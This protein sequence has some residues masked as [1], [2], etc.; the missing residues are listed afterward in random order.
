MLGTNP[1]NHYFC[2][3]K[4]EGSGGGNRF[5]LLNL[6]FVK[7]ISPTFQKLINPSTAKKVAQSPYTYYLFLKA[8]Q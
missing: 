7:E 1:N 5:S 8:V 4:G 2:Y 3:T 6:S